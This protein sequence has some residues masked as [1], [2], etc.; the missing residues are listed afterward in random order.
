MAQQP[1]ERERRVLY[2]GFSL[3]PLAGAD[4]AAQQAAVARLT[5]I[6]EASAVTVSQPAD[7]ARPWASAGRA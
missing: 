3:A 5:A 1:V 6:R 7:P 4:L 2:T